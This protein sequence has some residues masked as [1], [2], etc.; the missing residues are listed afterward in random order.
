M[1]GVL[2]EHPQW[3]VPLFAELERRGLA[4]ERILA[5]S[6]LYDPAEK[7]SPYALVFNRMSPSAYL[8]GHTRSIFATRSYLA[9]LERLGTRVINGSAAYGLELSK[10]AQLDLLS[11]IG[12]PAPATH[13]VNNTSQI[14]AAAAELEFPLILKP[15][16]GGS[17]ALMRRIQSRAELAAALDGEGPGLD[18]VFGI[19]GTALVQEYHPPRDGA[20]VRAEVL[21]GKLLYAI[22]IH[23]DPDQGFNLCPADICQIPPTNSGADDSFDFCPADVPAKASRKIEA[24]EPPEWVQHAVLRICETAGLDLGGVE[25]LESERDGRSYFYDINALSNFVTDA[26]NVVGFDPFIRLG[27]FVERRWQAATKAGTAPH[28]IRDA[29]PALR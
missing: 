9:H 2:Y 23:N 27:D 28:V 10:A 19:D 18:D 14:E 24:V 16:V 15:N 3:F 1:I 12:L 25:Y 5:E 17:G 4:Y 26:P 20:I 13:V 29:V 7:V 11:A 22:R 6:L 21:D 8:R